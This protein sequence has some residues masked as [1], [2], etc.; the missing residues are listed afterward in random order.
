M[1]DNWKHR[2]YIAL[3]EGAPTQ[4]LAS[5]RFIKTE[6]YFKRYPKVWPFK[7]FSSFSYLNL[8]SP[9]ITQIDTD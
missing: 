1:L 7:S 9:Q 8:I 4:Y 3:V 2:G 6:E 5:Q